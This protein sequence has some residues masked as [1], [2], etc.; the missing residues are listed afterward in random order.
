MSFSLLNIFRVGVVATLILA[1]PETAPAGSVSHPPLPTKSFPLS[2]DAPNKRVLIYTE[3]N[4]ISWEKPNPHWGVVFR[5]GKLGDKAIFTAFCSPQEFHQALIRIDA[6]PGNNLTMDQQGAVVQGDELLVSALWP[7]HKHP[8]PLKDLISDQAGLGFRVRFGGNLERAIQEK[9]GCITC[10][11]SCP[12]G[13]TSNAAYP[14]ISSFKRWVSPNSVFK[15]RSEHFP[16]RESTPVI[17]IYQ[18]KKE[19]ISP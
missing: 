18:L 6:R 15:G 4:Q 16:L 7:G 11:E 13:I 9:T 5:E 2:I 10:L 1:L 12:V 14:T 3:I 19:P 17:L 8:I